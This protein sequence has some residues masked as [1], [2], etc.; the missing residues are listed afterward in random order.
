MI[1]L[2][3][4]MQ[5]GDI[6][7]HTNGKCHLC[8]LSSTCRMSCSIHRHIAYNTLECHHTH[9]DI[10]IHIYQQNAHLK[11]ECHEVVTLMAKFVGH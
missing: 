10:Y 11:A 2:R 1:V 5:E 8:T 6:L 7:E 9:T 3:S 4:S